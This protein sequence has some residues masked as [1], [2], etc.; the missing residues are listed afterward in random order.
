MV[1][2]LFFI[3]L[4]LNY[5]YCFSQALHW[6]KTTDCSGQFSQSLVT[7]SGG[8]LVGTYYYNNCDVDFDSS[9]Q[10]FTKSNFNPNLVVSKYNKNG[11]LKWAK[12]IY[13]WGY[14]GGNFNEDKNGNIYLF[15]NYSNLLIIDPSNANDTLLA[16]GTRNFLAKFDSIGNLLWAKNVFDSSSAGSTKVLINKSG[17]IYICGEFSGQ[18]DIDPSSNQLLL[19]TP[20]INI[21]NTLLLKCDS[22]GGMIWYKQ[23]KGGDNHL[24]YLK[25]DNNENLI[26]SGAFVD[27]IDTDPSIGQS[28]QYGNTNYS[29]AVFVKLDTSGNLVWSNS[30]KGANN[31]NFISFLDILNVELDNNDYMFVTGQLVNDSIDFDNGPNVY[32]V[33]SYDKPTFLMKL[34]SNGNFIDVKTFDHTVGTANDNL[35]IDSNNNIYMGVQFFKSSDLDPGLYTNCIVNSVS[36][37]F[38]NRAIIK[39][40]TNLI[41]NNILLFKA[42]SFNNLGN[43]KFCLDVDTNIYIFASDFAKYDFFIGQCDS[44]VLP[45]T[46]INTVLGFAKYKFCSEIL[47]RNLQFC[48]SV[49]LFDS[50]YYQST[51]FLY[52]TCAPNGCDSLINIHLTINKK[53]ADT[54]TAKACKTYTLNNIT[55]TS[56]GKYTQHFTNSTGCD[57]AVQIALTIESSPIT[58]TKI[59]DTLY[60]T[61]VGN[62]LTYQWYK[63]SD[64]SI[65]VGANQAQ[66]IGAPNTDY[67][68]MVG[69]SE[70]CFATSTCE[71]LFVQ[72]NLFTRPNLEIFPNP[73][74]GI[75]EII[76]NNK[77][78]IYKISLI[79]IYGKIVFE[80]MNI[81][82]NQHIVVDIANIVAG[83]YTLQI[84]S[85]KGKEIFKLLKK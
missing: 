64:S 65:V 44:L 75:V 35:S 84:E 43:F 22:N 40:D 73:T 50:T 72:A 41:F 71:P 38:L 12:T 7:K 19:F 85:V 79:D 67:Y 74:N 21:F 45:D 66:F 59:V 23:F 11:Q 62:N 69:F 36:Q 28:V 61:T 49:Q 80:T 60:P 13:S 53:S 5:N 25:F 56:S 10:V 83:V 20:N 2:F 3:T 30:L 26:L 46:L 47:E 9:N 31:N 78:V 51:N 70:A 81:N 57:S 34:N 58:V 82:A 14:N 32:M 6:A 8:I 18:I 63:C 42:D 17:E 37:N 4:I 54:I 1:R 15:G 29:N 39:F 68:V 27:S 48:D 55:Y 33:N 76:N 16:N 24:S 77:H 52:T